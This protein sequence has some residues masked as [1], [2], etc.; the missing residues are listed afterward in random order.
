MGANGAVSEEKARDTDIE[1]RVQ[2]LH[3][4]ES[5]NRGSPI[6]GKSLC[7]RAKRRQNLLANKETLA[8]RKGRPKRL[9]KKVARNVL[10]RRPWNQAKTE[11]DVIPEERKKENPEINF[12]EMG[13]VGA[14][15]ARH[16]SRNRCLT[17]GPFSVC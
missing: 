17:A 8:A 15:T 11:R 9:R 2:E 3:A 5:K 14:I 16:I 13:G 6:R 12:R 7:L 1:G 10:K 4:S